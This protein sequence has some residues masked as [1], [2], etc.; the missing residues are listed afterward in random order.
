VINSA[1]AKTCEK[2][3]QD[4]A[5]WCKELASVDDRI[6]QSRTLYLI[7]AGRASKPFIK[8]DGRETRPFM[9][10]DGRASQPSIVSRIADLIVTGC[11]GLG[12]S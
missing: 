2:C 7:K 12:V 8:Q 1:I 9:E 10:R 4:W 5:V 6:E 11:G 3:V